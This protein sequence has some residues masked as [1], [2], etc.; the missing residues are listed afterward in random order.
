MRDLRVGSFGRCQEEERS[1]VSLEWTARVASL[2]VLFG[3]VGA[4][5]WI[6]PRRPRF[7]K[8]LE[9]PSLAA[10]LLALLGGLSFA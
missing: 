9:S 2:L 4:S 6:P 1:R 3:L 5:A 7:E 10:L 8:L